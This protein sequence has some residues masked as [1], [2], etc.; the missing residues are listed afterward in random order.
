MRTALALP[1]AGLLAGAAVGLRL[2]DTP[3]DWLVAALVG[4][5]V[6]AVHAAR[7][8]QPLLL[9]AAAFGA[10]LVGGAALSADAWH[11]AWRPPLRVVFESIAQDQRSEA[12][13]SGRVVPEE[14]DA[15]VVLIGVLRAD[16]SPSSGGAVSLSV[17]VE[18]LG[19]AL[20][21]SGATDPAANPAHGGVLLTVLGRLALEEMPAWRSGRRIRAT[22]SLRR[23]ARYLDPGVPDQERALARRGVS[24]VGTVKSGALVSVVSEGSL[25]GEWAARVRA[26]SR[27]AMA[28]SVGKW[29]VR[30]AAIV[31]AIVIGD[32]TG[33][34]ADVERRL[35]ESGTYHVIAIS[36]G[37]IALLAGL[38]LAVFRV[39]GVLGR[40]AMLSAALGLVVYGIVVGGGASVDRAVF[41]ACVYFV[42]RAWDMRGPPFQSLVLAAGVLCLADPLSIADPASLLTFGATLAIVAVAPMV[43]QERIPR[44]LRPAVNM[45]AASLAVELLLLPVAASYFWRVTF[46]GLALNFAAI[47][48]MAVAQFAGMG[49]VP[50]HAVWPAASHFVGWVAFV[51]AEGLVRTADAVSYAPWSTW[52]V[53]PPS[54]LAVVVYYTALVT[55][56]VVARKPSQPAVRQSYLTDPPDQPDAHQARLPGL[57]APSV[58]PRLRPMLMLGGLAEA[59]A[60]AVSVAFRAPVVASVCAVAAGCV[61]VAPTALRAT[62]G[63][64]LLHVTFIDVGQGDAALV[65]FPRGSSMLIDTGG[66]TGTATFDIG[67]RVVMPVLWNAGVYRLDVLAL[68]HG[69]ADH[70]GGAPTVLRE[71]RPSEAW[72]GVPVPP[73]PLLTRLRET[74]QAQRTR[75]TTLQRGD[76]TSVDGVEVRVV[77]PPP[78]DWERQ[79]VRNDDSIVLELRWRE[80]SF[81]FTGDIGRDT[82]REIA[83]MFEPARLRV[84]KVPHHG[85][86]TSSSE[87]FVRALKPNVAVISVGRSNTF[88]HPSPAVLER[89]AAAGTAVHRTDTC[90][91]VLVETDGTTL[92]LNRF[93]ENH[94]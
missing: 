52:R 41:M 68:T 33:L 8:R 25:V 60:E 84:L 5:A 73:H 49:V 65:R 72:E 11:R 93:T 91:A 9:V 86:I 51:G 2:P 4:W 15:A 16:A 34:D 63:D 13:Q 67:E 23:P 90:G 79:D 45:F 31:S 17:E 30:A 58:A 81:V 74:T 19:S 76:R 57:P 47:P 54:T 85:S 29:S 22:A 24:L 53:P 37:N 62:H 3:V 20:K 88:G 77:H 56:W 64:G 70:A 6:L 28:D 71:F 1:V 55:A 69:D 80:V 27:R 26:F 38:T 12:I 82:E 92:L 7:V 14:S 83:S 48:L 66:L 32:R 10:F 87:S 44:V 75:W 50:L 18:W 35:Q 43:P 42:G 94:P 21:G 61:I 89:Y 78:P 59:S 36:G 39:A 40:A 46:A